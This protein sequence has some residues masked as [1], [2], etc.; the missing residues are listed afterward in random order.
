[1]SATW[2]WPLEFGQN[3]EGPLPRLWQWASDQLWPAGIL[4]ARIL[5][6]LYMKY[7]TPSLPHP[8]PPAKEGP[9][10]ENEGWYLE[11]LNKIELVLWIKGKEKKLYF[12]KE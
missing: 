7:S 10:Y 6:S 1:M 8:S 3:T 9:C 12:S 2:F 4:D 5:P 11:S